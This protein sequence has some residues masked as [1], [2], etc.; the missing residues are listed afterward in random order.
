MTNS[1]KRHRPLSRSGVGSELEAR[2]RAAVRSFDFRLG[3]DF[4][5][6]D[7][8]LS[9]ELDVVEEGDEAHA[10]PGETAEEAARAAETSPAR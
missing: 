2:A 10:G 5:L 6:V 4:V 7:R 8:N 1:P 3:V 9:A